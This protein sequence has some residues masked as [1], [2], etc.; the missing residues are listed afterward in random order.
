M[1]ATLQRYE[2]AALTPTVLLT[3]T[4]TRAVAGLVIHLPPALRGVIL[5]RRVGQEFADDLAQVHLLRVALS[6]RLDNLTELQQ[7]GAAVY[8]VAVEEVEKAGGG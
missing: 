6:G 8:S 2:F 3:T 5:G 4:V 1:V 7:V